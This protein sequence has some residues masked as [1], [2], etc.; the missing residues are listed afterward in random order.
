MI[1]L[2]FSAS[3][4]FLSPLYS[5]SLTRL[6]WIY[7]TDTWSKKFGTIYGHVWLWMLYI[8]QKYT[9]LVTIM[10]WLVSETNQISKPKFSKQKVW[11]KIKFA[12][13]KH[14]KIHSCHV[15]VMFMP[16]HMIWKRQQCVHIHSHIMRY[17]TINVHCG[18]VPN[19]HVFIFLTKKH[20]ISIPTP[21]LQ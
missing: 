18:V 11:W 20:M 21:V 13:M 1:M 9:F 15:G 12:Y 8:F 19:V 14:I 10:A 17:N 6:L 16:K 4:A 7:W 3:L 5:S 2:L